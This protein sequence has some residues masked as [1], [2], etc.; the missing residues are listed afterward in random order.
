MTTFLAGAF[1][2]LSNVDWEELST[3]FTHPAVV[4]SGLAYSFTLLAILLAHEL[5]HYLMCQRYGIRASLPYFIPAPPIIGIGTFGAFIRIQEPI[6]SRRA[7]FD[8]GIAGPL[9]G[10]V[11][12]LPATIVGLWFA[13]PAPPIPRSEGVITFND[14]ALFI[15][16]QRVFDL[17]VMIQWNPV[18]FAAWVGMLATSL[19]LLPL[20]QLDG[21]HIAYA[22][23]GPRGH[24][25]MARG[26]FFLMI[27]LA[28]YAYDRH[29]WI[30]WFVY[31][32]LI[33]L[34]I[35]LKHPPLEDEQESLDRRRKVLGIIALIVF[36]LSFMPFPITIT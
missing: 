33:G 6:R 22:L 28:F 21:G 3:A 18:H 31:V 4:S 19:N 24:R 1:F 9:A 15:L 23:L 16:L 29:R 34:L 11:V 20:G 26:I 13:D 7:L 25:W 32:G 5:G 17:P 14:P 30:G 8:V 10:F 2:A 12:A 35:G 27:G 36:A